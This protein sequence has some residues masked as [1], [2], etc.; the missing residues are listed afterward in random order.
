MS[1]GDG[2]G[3]ARPQSRLRVLRSLEGRR[4]I[5]GGAAVDH[6]T[7]PFSPSPIS[8]SVSSLSTPPPPHRPNDSRGALSPL[9]S[10]GTLTPP[11]SPTP[12]PLPAQQP[13]ASPLAPS[14]ARAVSWVSC[15]APST[16]RPL[17][18]VLSARRSSGGAALLARDVFASASSVAGE[19]LARCLV[20]G[21]ELCR[22]AVVSARAGSPRP[23]GDL[24]APS[25]ERGSAL[26]SAANA[27]AAAAG[28]R[29]AEVVD[30][31]L[32]WRATQREPESVRSAL[33]AAVASQQQQ[34]Q[35]QAVAA[36]GAGAACCPQ[37]FLED[38]YRA[39]VELVVATIARALVE[40]KPTGGV[41]GHTAMKLLDA[42]MEACLRP[43][44][45]FAESE[46]HTLCLATSR[47]QVLV[48]YAAVV[49]ALSHVQLAGAT[50]FVNQFAALLKT[51]YTAVCG[52]EVKK[53]LFETVYALLSP[54]LETEYIEGVDNT[55]WLVAIA[56]LLEYLRLAQKPKRS[57]AVVATLLC[58]SEHELF[59]SKWVSI[60][61][62]I[63]HAKERPQKSLL[64][65]SLRVILWGLL[66]RHSQFV[67]EPEVREFVAD[68]NSM[69]LA[70]GRRLVSGTEPLMPYVDVIATIA[71]PNI[72]V[73]LHMTSE[74]LL[75]E[76]SL[77]D[78]NVQ[79]SLAAILVAPRQEILTS[80]TCQDRYCMWL[81]ASLSSSLGQFLFRH[82]ISFNSDHP[83]VPA[84]HGAFSRV[85]QRLQENIDTRYIAIEFLTAVLSCVPLFVPNQALVSSESLAVLMSRML[86]HPEKAVRECA[87]NSLH[88]VLSFHP[89]LRSSI[90]RGLAEYISTMPE[91]SKA[92]HS[93]LHQLSHILQHW[94]QAE[95]HGEDGGCPVLSIIPS[96]DRQASP[97]DAS[98]VE[99]VAIKCLC[100]VQIKPRTT[101]LKI[102]ESISKLRRTLD[103]SIYQP[104]ARGDVE[105]WKSPVVRWKTVAELAS[106]ESQSDTNYWIFFVSELVKELRTRCKEAMRM[107]WDMASGRLPYLLRFSDLTAT[108]PQVATRFSVLQPELFPKASVPVDHGQIELWRNYAIFLSSA[109]V[110]TR[111]E[112]LVEEKKRWSFDFSQVAHPQ[113]PISF[114]ELIQTLVPYLKSPEQLRDI[115]V[116]ALER[117]NP[118]YY[119]LLFDILKPVDREF[120]RSTSKGKRDRVKNIMWII[121]GYIAE[122][123]PADCIRSSEQLTKYTAEVITEECSFFSQP[124][125]EF[126]WD[127]LLFARYN[128]AVLVRR[129]AS[130]RL[131]TT[132]LSAETRKDLFTLLA[133]WSLAEN[134]YNEEQN[135]KRVVNDLLSLIKDTKHRTTVEHTLLDHTLYLQYASKLFLG[136][137]FTEK[138]LFVPN[139]TA[140]LWLRSVFVKEKRITTRKE[141][142]KARRARELLR[143]VGVESACAL[144][145][146]AGSLDLVSFYVSEC[147]SLNTRVSKGYFYAL[148]DYFA[149]NGIPELPD[150]LS[151]LLHLAVF[152]SGDHRAKV[153]GRAGDLLSVICA[154]TK[155]TVHQ[156]FACE[157]S[158][159]AA[160][161]SAQASLSCTL[162]RKYNALQYSFINE[163][164]KRLESDI[165]PDRKR[166]M[167]TYIIPWVDRIDMTLLSPTKTLVLE[168]LLYLSL[169]QSAEHPNFINTLWTTIAKP[170]NVGPIVTCILDI[171]EAKELSF[172][173]L[174]KLICLHIGLASPRSIVDC[175][176]GELVQ[177]TN[178]EEEQ[179]EAPEIRPSPRT[180][181]SDLPS[182][183]HTALLDAN[184]M[185]RAHLVVMLLAELAFI[186]GEEF[187]A[188]LH[189]ILHIVFLGFDFPRLPLYDQCRL[190]LANL[191]RGY[192]CQHFEM[193][194]LNPSD[195]EEYTAALKLWHFLKSKEREQLWNAPE[196]SSPESASRD[197]PELVSLVTQVV[198]V[199]SCIRRD[200]EL[201]EKWGS[202]AFMW[203]IGCVETKQAQRSCQIYRALRPQARAGQIVEVLYHVCDSLSSGVPSTVLVCEHLR[204]IECMLEGL[205][206]DDLSAFPQV[207]WGVVALLQTDCE[208]HYFLAARMLLG[209]LRRP[210]FRDPMSEGL[211]RTYRPKPCFPFICL[212]PL[213]VRGLHSAVA[214]RVCFES[215]GHLSS[216]PHISLLCP[217]GALDVPMMTTVLL[218]WLSENIEYGQKDA[219]LCH[220][221]AAG[222]AAL[223]MP[224]LVQ[225]SLLRY[226]QSGFL[227]AEQFVTGV[228]DTLA[229]QCSD[230]PAE[231]ILFL[232]TLASAQSIR[233]TDC[234]MRVLGCL[235]AHY[236]PSVALRRLCDSPALALALRNLCA[237]TS[238]LGVC[239]E[240]VS[241]LTT[242]IALVTQ[243]AAAPAAEAEQQGGHGRPEIEDMAVDGVSALGSV[244]T[245]PTAFFPTP[246]AASSEGV[247]V[248]LLQ[249]LET[250]PRE[251]PSQGSHKLFEKFVQTF[252]TGNEEASGAPA[253]EEDLEALGLSM[254]GM[255]SSFA[256]LP[257]PAESSTS[258]ANM[259]PSPAGT[260]LS[261]SFKFPEF[262]G[263]EVACIVKKSDEQ[264]AEAKR[265]LQAKNKRAALRCLRRKKMYGMQ[266]KNLIA[267]RDSVDKQIH[268][269]TQMVG[270]LLRTKNNNKR[271]VV[272]R[273]RIK[274]ISDAHVEELMAAQDKSDEQIV[275]QAVRTGDD[276]MRHI[277]TSMEEEDVD[278][279]MEDIREQQDIARKIDDAIGQSQ[280]SG[281]VF[282]EA[283][284]LAELDEMEQDIRRDQFLSAPVTP[285]ASP[286]K[287]QAQARAQPTAGALVSVAVAAGD[288]DDE[289]ALLEA[290]MAM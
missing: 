18:P 174:A 232:L 126:L 110:V 76:G 7:P 124:A 219:E 278:Q 8:L 191:V 287:A 133:K 170:F 135:K 153:R 51:E 99:A 258:S 221:V 190:L 206:D 175:L 187:T 243:F 69:L 80:D 5:S 145:K 209:L 85:V 215:L 252:G 17:R 37:L 30:A 245:L 283:E 20:L 227:D 9:S 156:P 224:S 142:L 25:C 186:I 158:L 100:S 72:D 216:M 70:P 16:L 26:L 60:A 48:Y 57:C 253:N 247:C 244:V 119:W 234:G 97:M 132:E 275:T 74:L 230:N 276:A 265:Q 54:L 273:P 262:K 107:C 150:A 144:L 116:L 83:L 84:L 34:Q 279:T 137:L 63:L 193:I 125:N 81:K 181:S 79:E 113:K 22:A 228:E 103:Q 155:Q 147:Y 289:F 141:R 33:V 73:A 171:G 41:P 53:E 136:K 240:S 194:G 288:D 75:T 143:P 281:E 237:A 254:H 31:A 255:T 12:S 179:E 280:T 6:A 29:A 104:Q 127:N 78:L 21:A 67:L 249:V 58:L 267:A 13:R 89:S 270:L 173:S 87:S 225:E 62:H 204:M 120:A 226:S 98:F 46:Q 92:L 93:V 44:R 242:L 182:L 207:F 2:G 195:S 167:L 235:I 27:L 36:G 90:V 161:L 286:V 197:I 168:N 164:V 284:L 109:A 96:C 128:F 91:N 172:V 64:L 202:E 102:L 259:P 218:P 217:D 15:S 108:A 177:I 189:V 271:L 211:L 266:I 213:L 198:S 118:D 94:I 43:E 77:Q 122:H 256:R 157:S 282:D 52:K 146:S 274:K 166:Q 71:G 86:M 14:H 32:E 272:W 264:V 28:Q 49:A 106:S 138:E 201:K 65:E 45:K 105:V 11:V 285:T 68:I 180:E 231:K 123:A 112:S 40:T 131:S 199:L 88:L 115:A 261:H 277:H 140:F 160:Y 205:A 10:S 212:H 248:S 114:K 183:L 134:L 82:Q 192:V 61:D 214:E 185:S 268:S 269:W 56:T 66:Y 236:A 246:S 163:V 257:Q 250:C 178:Q 3:H 210:L 139:N 203:A 148:V 162:S 149:G 151:V 130:E 229:L 152:M 188:Y 129:F 238:G 169:M 19:L 208:Q 184:D 263:F 111:T 59:R 117:C 101:S 233:R 159:S 4:T 23:I 42:A 223:S 1:D 154:A 95:L 239:I 290:Q 176:A 260:L 200:G 50:V 196:D 24:F 55:A 222:L 38:T 121:R 47:R 35:Q 165:H 220:G 39:A 241:R 251:S